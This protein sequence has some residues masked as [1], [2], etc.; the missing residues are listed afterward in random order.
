MYGLGKKGIV[1]L[2]TVGLILMLSLLILKSVDVSQKYFER[3][4]ERNLLVQLDKSFLDVL[5]ILQKSS[6]N[7]RD[8][9]SLST[10]IGLPI[11]LNTDS[12]DINVMMDIS[13]A[14]GVININNLIS[15][16]NR[17]NEPL[18]NFLQSLLYEYRVINSNFFLSI[19]LDAIDI[20]KNERTY[21]SEASLQNYK[22]SDG[23]ID[24]KESFNYLLDYFVANGGDARIYDIPWEDVI[25]FVGISIDF[26]YIKEPLFTLI[27]KEYN[28]HSLNQDEIVSSYDELMISSSDR[29]KLTNLGIGFFSPK[30]LCSMS[31]FYL[32][33]TKLLNFLYDIRSEKVDYVETIF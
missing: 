4:N 12:G 14:G 33:Q 21:A 20:D 7:I 25:G 26:N 11:I 29:E 1:L 9:Q 27:K 5:A 19:L 6:Q 10:I 31:F 13:S 17:I 2:T 28:L 24:S 15:N 3:A 16:D 23:G 32:G 18:Y 30:I 8:A 22:F